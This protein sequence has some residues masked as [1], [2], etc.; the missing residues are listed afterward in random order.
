MTYRK[1]AFWRH[2]APNHVIHGNRSTL[3]LHR[4]FQPA[5]GDPIC[6]PHAPAR[7]PH[8][9]GRIAEVTEDPLRPQRA[10]YSMRSQTPCRNS[11]AHGHAPTTMMEMSDTT[12][13][14]MVVTM[15]VVAT[16]ISITI[17]ITVRM[18]LLHHR[19][20]SGCWKEDTA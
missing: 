12:M 20:F 9:S 8:M 14:I 7:F 15:V 13:V 18:F 2:K 3:G 4:H 17:I 19:F 16:G 11:L 1:L 6:L 10:P 5:K